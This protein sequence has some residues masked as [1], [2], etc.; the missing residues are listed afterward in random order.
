MSDQNANRPFPARVLPLSGE[1]LIS[2]IRRT[3]DAMG[4]ERIGRVVALL[5]AWGSLPPSLDQLAPG[6]TLDQLA[7]LCRQSIDKLIA[8]TVHSYASS[9]VL[10]PTHRPLATV[11]DSQTA[12][13]YFSSSRP[14][15]PGCLRDDPIPYERLLWSARFIRVCCHHSCLLLSRCPACQRPL[16]WD[17]CDVTRCAC[18]QQF[19]DIDLVPVSSHASALVTIYRRMVLEDA[20]PIPE[21][22]GVACFWW[23][24]K[25]ATAISKT[26]AWIARVAEQ[27]GLHPEQHSEAIA[28]LGAAQILA[29]W[30]C[31]LE[32]FLEVFQQVDKHKTTATGIGRRFGLFLRRAVHLEELGYPTPATALRQYLLDNYAGGHLSSKVCLFQ[33]GKDRK[34]LKRRAWIPQT[35]AGKMLGL[36]HGAVAKLVR[37]GIL[38]GRLHTAGQQGR[39]VGLV[40]RESVESL[41]G[42]LREAFNLQTAAR[43]LGIGRH[44][45]L[46]LIRTGTLPRA[47]RTAQGWR[48]P[49]ASITALQE[50]CRQLLA[51]N[52]SQRS[53]D[54]SAWLSLREA[55]RLFGRTGLTLA[56]LIEL[57]CGGKVTACIADPEKALNG[58]LVSRHDLDRLSPQIR[59]Q[60][61]QH[62]GYSLHQLGKQLFLG[63]PIKP[64]VL[65]KWVSMKL[66]TGETCGRVFLV[67]AAEVERFRTAY[68]LADEACRLLG[69]VRETLARWER[70]G[71]IQPVYGKRITPGAGFSLY[72]RDDLKGL[73]RRKNPRPG[74]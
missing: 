37:D 65:K 55:T 64:T 40:L 34:A 30:P 68:C 42:E 20:S 23:A 7:G 49:R 52:P 59:R 15:C 63:R 11:C 56:R 73:S 41:Q 35:Q 25:L 58:I 10:V 69:I 13:R 71:R 48:I 2:F 74:K 36:R 47:V 57:L 29:D 8:L 16:R 24:D 45:V 26:P 44:R 21:M 12:F 9:L 43:C 54:M 14:V 39:S 17:R 53:V 6:P 67:S 70:E 46:D 5:T 22:S 50:V 72:R 18:G 4:Y 31:G 62:H 19:S 27:V 28:W 33:K 60:R 1:S 3:S 66:L 32:K 61:D 51:V 38:E